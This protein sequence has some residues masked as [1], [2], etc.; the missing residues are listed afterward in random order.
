ME[1]RNTVLQCVSEGLIGNE[2]LALNSSQLEVGFVGDKCGR[3]FS[4]SIWRSL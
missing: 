1:Q 4:V 2:Y 3:R